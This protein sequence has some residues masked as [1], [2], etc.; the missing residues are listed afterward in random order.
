MEDVIQ[1]KLF[2][3]PNTH[4]DEDLLLAGQGDFD[5]DGNMEVWP[6]EEDEDGYI[7]PESHRVES[8]GSNLSLSD[9]STME[10]SEARRVHRVA[11]KAYIAGLRNKSQLTLGEQKDLRAA[12]RAQEARRI[13]N[14]KYREKKKAQLEE[15]NSPFSPSTAGPNFFNTPSKSIA[16]SVNRADWPRAASEGS[17]IWDEE[18][19]PP[20]T[21]HEAAMVLLSLKNGNSA[22]TDPTDRFATISL[23]PSPSDTLSAAPTLRDDATTQ[24]NVVTWRTPRTKENERLRHN[25]MQRVKRAERKAY[26]EGLKAK[27]YRIAAEEHELLSFEAERE[28]N[29]MKRRDHYRRKEQERL[30]A[31]EKE[32]EEEEESPT[33]EVPRL[34]RN[35]VSQTSHRKKKPER[36]NRPDG[37][38]PRKPSQN[39]LAEEEEQE[40]TVIVASQEPIRDAQLLTREERHSNKLVP[41]NRTPTEKTAV[42]V[43]DRDA[44][45]AAGGST[46]SQRELRARNRALQK[47][48]ELLAEVI[49]ESEKDAYPTER[50]PGARTKEVDVDVDM[51]VKEE[52][53]M[54]DVDVDVDVGQPHH[55]H[56][57][58]QQASPPLS[59]VPSASPS[60]PPD[61]FVPP[62]EESESD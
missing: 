21:A 60:L 34:R 56:A 13:A 41:V 31:L 28:A 48:E 20:L 62:G 46:M 7:Y 8:A 54:M 18:L 51:D 50:E 47:E 23:S 3:I 4:K 17:T 43:A 6:L 33:G 12:N 42:A 10:A 36:R 26:I 61:V 1:S 49:R 27:T 59:P 14:K 45:A 39:A 2:V 53:D 52:E 25:E 29:C 44:S 11:H 24:A 38:A 32:A 16:Q 35:G 15:I 57:Q 22:S 40:D 9:I 58:Q 5:E 19:R 55:A 37:A 30:Q